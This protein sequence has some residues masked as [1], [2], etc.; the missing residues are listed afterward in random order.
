MK[1]LWAGLLVLFATTSAEADPITDIVAARNQFL[2]S[3]SVIVDTPEPQDLESYLLSLPAN[4]TLALIEQQEGTRNRAEVRQQDGDR[5]IVAAFQGFGDNNQAQIN[6]VGS[7]NFVV[8]SQS[9]NSNQVMPLEQTGNDNIAKLTQ[10][11]DGNIAQVNQISDA[12]SLTLRQSDGYN[13]ALVN[14]YGSAALDITQANPG[15]SPASV[16]GLSVSAYI[17]PGY[18]SNFGPI[19]LSG[20]GQT[21]VTLCSG[22]AGF[23]A[24]Y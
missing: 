22:S 13:N 18:T 10:Q 11:G 24:Q 1:K 16:N 4:S 2:D 19:Q 15:G 9:G 5:N 12:N 14:Q 23:C 6:Q 8:V 3:G 7:G 17:E 21:A 20:E